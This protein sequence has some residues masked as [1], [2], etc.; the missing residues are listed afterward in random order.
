MDPMH[1]Q[2]RAVTF[3]GWRGNIC[4]SIY[5]GDSASAEHKGGASYH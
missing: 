5:D 1:A 2:G 4:A 3:G